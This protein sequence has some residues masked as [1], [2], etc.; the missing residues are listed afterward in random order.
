M[1]RKHEREIG[2]KSD[3]CNCMGEEKYGKSEKYG[4]EGWVRGRCTLEMKYEMRDVGIV[5]KYRKSQI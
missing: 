5:E 4:R 1:G 3:E 2:K